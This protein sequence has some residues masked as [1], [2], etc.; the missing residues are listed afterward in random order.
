MICAHALKIL[1]NTLKNLEFLKLL[2]DVTLTYSLCW[3]LQA[4]SWCAEGVELLA[5]QQLDKFNTSDGAKSA[6]LSV[7]QFVASAHAHRQLSDTSDL[8]AT[9]E[10][11]MTPLTKVNQNRTPLSW[12]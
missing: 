4:N 7:E 6:L 9:F 8:S 3:W 1:K 12:T 2:F 11:V 10:C 5:K